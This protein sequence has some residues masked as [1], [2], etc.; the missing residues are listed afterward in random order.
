RVLT[1][2]GGTVVERLS[3]FAYDPGFTGGVFV[4]GGDVDGRPGAELITGPGAG[5]GPHVRIFRSDA[6][7]LSSFFAYDLPFR[8]G[9]TVP[10]FAPVTGT[11]DPPASGG[12]GDDGGD[13]GGKHPGEG[14]PKPPKH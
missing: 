5:G 7:E 8:G 9:V 12:D 6:T 13:Q 14:K 4:A 10:G 11:V 1:V 2:T 3:F